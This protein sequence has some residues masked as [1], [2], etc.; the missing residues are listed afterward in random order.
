MKKTLLAVLA[1]LILAPAGLQA[2]NTTEKAIAKIRKD[3]ATANEMI[4]AVGDYYDGIFINSTTLD[5]K[6]MWFPSGPH[7]SKTE[8]FY[9]LGNPEDWSEWSFDRNVFFVRSKWNIAPREYYCEF[10]FD[11]KTGNPEFYFYRVMGYDGKE[12]EYRYYWENGKLIRSICPPNP[13]DDILLDCD[14][15][16]PEGVY[17]KA[18][19]YQ[20]SAEALSNY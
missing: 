10:L 16:N 9:V 5:I 14:I 3:Y 20:N 8:I 12:Y 1:A 17:K 2:Q 18:I 15:P 4:K 13:G 19:K 11:P 6:E 7:A